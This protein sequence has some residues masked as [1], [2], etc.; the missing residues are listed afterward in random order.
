MGWGG[1]GG[2][3]V[4]DIVLSVWFGPLAGQHNPQ[5]RASDLNRLFK[6]GGPGASAANDER[7]DGMK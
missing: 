4:V 5:R 3:G 2:V 7:S 1:R 6:M